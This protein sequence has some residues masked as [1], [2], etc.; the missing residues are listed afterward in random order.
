MLLS[1]RKKLIDQFGIKNIINYLRR[2]RQDEERE[3]K[4]G[5][6]TLHEQKQLMDRV[7]NEY[8]I[9]YNQVSEIGSGD[10]ISTRPVFM[11]VIRDLKNEKYEAIAVKEISRMGRGSYTD[12]GTIYDLIIEKRIYI[13]TPSK[14]YDPTN[15]ADLRHI[16][17]ELFLSREEFES[18]KERLNGGRYN[19]ALEGKWVSGPPPFGFDYSPATGRLIINEEEAGIV[20]AIFDYYANGI[21]L[22]NGK[23]KLVQFR[24]L[25]TYLKRI[26]IK[27]PTGK[28]NWSPPFLKEFLSHDRYIGTLRQNTR[29]TLSNGKKVPRPEEEHIVVEKAHPAIID[30]EIWSKVQYR[31]NNRDIPTHTKLDFEPNRLAGLCICKKCGKK[32]IRRASERTYIKKDGSVSYYENEFLFCG[33]VG[34][35][36]VKYK[37]VEEDILETLKILKDLNPSLLKSQVEKI[38]IK[39]KPIDSKEDIIKRIKSRREELDR[40]MK[41][42]YEKH[43][44]GVYSDERFLERKA[45]IDKEL[46]ELAKINVEDQKENENEEL[47][48]SVIK[49]NLN[50]VLQAYENT[51]S[52][53]N[54][55]KLLHSV[56]SHIFIEIVKKG[57][58]SRP[59]THQIEP[60]LKS[61]VLSKPN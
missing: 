23:R 34:C 59:A 48:P 47:D 16:R 31:I 49:R 18:T 10:K 25:A 8:R 58:G 27:T 17:F 35:T 5:E 12:M 50:S 24:A 43:E 38:V 33:T 55:N 21:I 19:A 45:E 57:S 54:K 6:D 13:I 29:Q 36:Y 42:I 37:P 32:F 22:N 52:E 60:Y 15:P 44:T 9:P 46:E 30:M 53:L 7:L 4:T 2:S 26:G 11:Q 14:I 41:F 1:A 56:F 61:T 39:E 3:K 51:T 28:D 20:R 40:R